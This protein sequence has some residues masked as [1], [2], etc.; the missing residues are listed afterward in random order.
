MTCAGTSKKYLRK[1]KMYINNVTT[2]L[3][4]LPWEKAPCSL[5]TMIAVDD[6]VFRNGIFEDAL[7]G[8]QLLNKQTLHCQNAHLVHQCR[9]NPVSSS[10]H[11]LVSAMLSHTCT[12]WN[13]LQL[14]SIISFTNSM[15]SIPPSGASTAPHQWPWWL[16]GLLA[17]LW[18]VLFGLSHQP[19][20]STG[21]V[22]FIKDYISFKIQHTYLWYSKSCDISMMDV[23]IHNEIVSNNAN[24][25]SSHTHTQWDGA[26]QFTQ[27][28]L[29]LLHLCHTCKVILKQK[30]HHDESI[31]SL[32]H[33]FH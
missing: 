6:A 7:R 22:R 3:E 4:R 5:N 26:Y 21:L 10:G 8:R 17:P 32:S 1:S 27:F 11:Q 12:Q 15:K 31:K 2:P 14:C 16:A 18:Q 24:K 28:C 13:V 19:E 23:H 20:G 25:S 29:V 9:E 30:T 33:Y